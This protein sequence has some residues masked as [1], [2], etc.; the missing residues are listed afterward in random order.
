VTEFIAEDL[1]D[2]LDEEQRLAAESL[3][4]PT[5]ILAGAG[6]GKTR[7]ITHRIA[8]GIAKGYYA[9]NRVL[10]L[11]YT[12]RAAGE[13]RSRLRA[14]GAAGVQVKTFHAAALSQL[15]FFWPQFAGVPAPQVLDSKAKLIGQAATE[16]GLKLDT[17]ALR[18]FAAGNND[19]TGANRCAN[20]DVYC[21][22]FSG[23]S[24][25]DLVL[26]FHGFKNDDCLSR[27]NGLTNFNENF[28]DGSLHW[29]SN[30][31]ASAARCSAT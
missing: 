10:A 17:A 25:L 7:T 28:N 22:D 31:A 9:A 27:L 11:T 21:R 24:C 8:Y 16:L 23:F 15:E 3:V 20:S 4:G 14:L 13:L 18:D 30:L 29:N 6:T 19:I 12:N 5:C 2:N 26:H 1:L